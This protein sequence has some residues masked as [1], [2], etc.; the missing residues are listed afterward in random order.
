[1]DNRGNRLLVPDNDSAINLPAVG[2]AHAIKQ[3]SAQA[4]DELSFDVCILQLSFQSHFPSFDVVYRK[5]CQ[6]NDCK[7]ILCFNI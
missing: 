7:Y 5:K 3:Y 6:N 2:A 4:S 1:M